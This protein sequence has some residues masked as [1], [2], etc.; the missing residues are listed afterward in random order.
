MLHH[1]TAIANF[2]MFTRDVGL[3]LKE[4]LTTLYIAGK[5][6]KVLSKASGS[7]HFSEYME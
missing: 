1:K 2:I 3:S 5:K 6:K 7:M 4:T